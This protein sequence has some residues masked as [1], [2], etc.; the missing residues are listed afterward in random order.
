MSL[1]TRLVC[2]GASSA[3]RKNF[4]QDF[5]Q[6]L[7]QDH[8]HKTQSYSYIFSK[9]HRLGL[10]RPHRADRKQRYPDD[11]TKPQHKKP[12]Y[13]HG[14]VPHL[15]RKHAAWCNCNAFR[16]RSLSTSINRNS[17]TIEHPTNSLSE[18]RTSK[19]CS[20][21]STQKRLGFLSVAYVRMHTVLQEIGQNNLKEKSSDAHSA[22]FCCKR[23]RFR[24]RCLATTTMRRWDTPQTA[25]RQHRHRDNTTELQHNDPQCSS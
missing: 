8:P 13:F 15:H 25:D 23:N 9:K 11:A 3:R 24:L 18:A 12:G 2:T 10:N 7:Q 14:S 21:T 17:E 4:A 5:A 1:V 6:I 19:Q 22:R 20:K 16:L